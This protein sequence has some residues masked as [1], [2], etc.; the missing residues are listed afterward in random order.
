MPSSDSEQLDWHRAGKQGCMFAQAMSVKY[1]DQ[2]LF[3]S[4]VVIDKEIGLELVLEIIDFV[5]KCSKQEDNQAASIIIPSIKSL[6]DLISFLK[7]IKSNFP[8]VFFETDNASIKDHTLIAIRFPSA[9]EDNISFWVLGFGNFEFLP[10]T[11]Q[12]P[13]FEIVFA[14]KSKD[15]LYKKYNRYS[16]LQPTENSKIRKGELDSAH[17]ADIQIEGTTEKTKKDNKLWENTQNQ[18]KAVLGDLYGDIRSK[19]KTSFTLPGDVR[20]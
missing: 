6:E 1:N 15:Y 14:T 19:A 7:L 16:H 9:F 5:N 10:K 8:G 18:K 2:S 3:W 12:S 11:R 4:R 20:F 13:L 17:L